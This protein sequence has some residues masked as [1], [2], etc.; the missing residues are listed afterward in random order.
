MDN[1]DTKNPLSALLLPKKEKY[2]SR[3]TLSEGRQKEILTLR[4]HPYESTRGQYIR[5][6]KE[7]TSTEKS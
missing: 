1:A 4:T 2:Y 3:C 6:K 7:G 5:D